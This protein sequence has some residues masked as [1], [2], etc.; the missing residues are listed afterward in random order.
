MGAL[1]QAIVQSI[2][3]GM[4]H[5]TS[6]VDHDA[7]FPETAARPKGPGEETAHNRSVGG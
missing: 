1:P 2:F 5:G 6:D 3:A 7:G 4:A